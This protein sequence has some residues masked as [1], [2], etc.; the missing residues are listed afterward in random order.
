MSFT[1]STNDNVALRIGNFQIENTKREK[2]LD[3]QFDSKL[4][5]DCH[6]SE[7]CKKA[8]RKLYALGRVT[9]YTNLSKR[10]ILMNAFFNSQFSYCPL[11][12]MCHSRI[13]NKKISRLH[14][15]CLKIIYCDKQSSFEELLEKES[16][17]SVHKRNIQ[18][19]AT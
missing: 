19:L 4:S 6:L 13:I 17:V 16:S 12:W 14:E 8:S 1:V 3:I 11:I 5:F 7:I 10:K 2:L 15:T 9:R 18:I